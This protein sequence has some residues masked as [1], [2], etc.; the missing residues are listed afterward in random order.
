MQ[1]II[2][3]FFSHDADTRYS[4]GGSMRLK[5]AII[6][7][8]GSTIGIISLLFTLLNN[9]DSSNKNNIAIIDNKAEHLMP[10]EKS[11]TVNQSNGKISE[12]SAQEKTDNSTD[13]DEYAEEY[14]DEEDDDDEENH[15]PLSDEDIKTIEQISALS[16]GELDNELNALKDRIEK[17]DLITELE[18]GTLDEKKSL[19]AKALLERFALLGMENTRRKYQT[20]EPELKNPIVAHRDSLREIREMLSEY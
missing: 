11:L 8:I 15:E 4:R 9:S 18:N 5:F 20:I 1:R 6:A 17:E 12:K 16:A 14:D 10:I 19:E 13:H 2:E 3:Q 7:I